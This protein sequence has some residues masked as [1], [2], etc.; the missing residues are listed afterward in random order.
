M[1][2]GGL[3]TSRFCMAVK[4]AGIFFMF[5]SVRKGRDQSHG[6]VLLQRGEERFHEGIWASFVLEEQGWDV[7][8]GPLGA[9][10]G[11]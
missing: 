11:G 5:C 6:I 10:D 1:E 2:V 8:M 9:A 3:G 4:L 7:A